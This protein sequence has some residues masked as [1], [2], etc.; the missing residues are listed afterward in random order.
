MTSVIFGPRQFDLFFS[1]KFI[2]YN[3]PVILVMEAVSEIVKVLPGNYLMNVNLI[4]TAR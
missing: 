3:L 1:L 2:S 4:L